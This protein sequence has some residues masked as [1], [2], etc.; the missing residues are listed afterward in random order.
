MTWNV[1]SGGFGGIYSKK[2]PQNT[3]FLVAPW[4]HRLHYSDEI[5]EKTAFFLHF[6]SWIWKICVLLVYKYD[7]YLVIWILDFPRVHKVFRGMIANCSSFSHLFPYFRTELTIIK[8]LFIVRTWL[9]SY[10]VCM[11]AYYHNKE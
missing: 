5:L 1:Y 11:S 10:F 8:K 6:E 7:S 9:W 4:N 3:H 2:T